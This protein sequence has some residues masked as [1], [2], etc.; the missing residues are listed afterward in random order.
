MSSSTKKRRSTQGQPNLQREALLNAA[1]DTM[2]RP[3][4][5]F[6]VFGDFVADQ[7]CQ[8]PP[9]KQKKLQLMIQR[10]ILLVCEEEQENNQQLIVISNCKCGN[11]VCNGSSL[12]TI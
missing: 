6:Q 10:N 1:I 5:T 8:L 3:T 4:D 9:E 7:L 11:C 12:E 2:K